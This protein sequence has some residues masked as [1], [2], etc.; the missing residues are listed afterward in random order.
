MA[1]D[2]SPWQTLL[3]IMNISLKNKTIFFETI[4]LFFTDSST[5]SLT[6]KPASIRNLKRKSYQLLFYGS[7]DGLVQ[8]IDMLKFNKEDIRKIWVSKKLT[9]SAIFK[10]FLEP[11]VIE[12][13]CFIY[14]VTFLLVSNNFFSWKIRIVT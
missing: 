14:V 3:R 4:G 7:Q 9:A 5:P 13:D 2:G 12:Q 8:V 6:T 11:Y 10:F 1:D